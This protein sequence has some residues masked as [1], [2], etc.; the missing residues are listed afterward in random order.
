MADRN[1]LNELMKLLNQP[2]PIN[3]AL[4]DQVAHHLSGS[5]EPIDP[6]LADEYLDLTRLAQMK[7]TEATGLRSYPISE[8]LLVDR[9]GWV[10][11]HLRSFRYVVDPLADKLSA[12]PGAGP[13]GSILKP[14]G[15]ALLGIQ[16]GA[17]VG[18]M[19]ETALGLFDAG[20]PTARP[21]GLTYLLPHIEAFA[22]DYGLDPRQVRLWAAL[23]ETAHGSLAGRSWVRPRAS[24]LFVELIGAM[25]LDTDVMRSFQENLAD[26]ARLESILAEAGG[27]AGLLGGSVEREDLEDIRRLSVM[28]EGY[29]SYLAGRAAGGF[30]PDLDTIRAAM[31]VHGQELGNR[32]GLVGWADARQDSR[33][34][35]FCDEVESRWGQQALGRMW[36]RA[37]NLPTGPELEDTTGWAARVLL[38]DPFAG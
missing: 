14:L 38:Q 9:P 25:E 11:N 3:W 19:S 1:L 28:L 6:W 18:T 8:T 10:R 17:M 22:I 23:R 34:L 5:P 29:G 20:L 16:M 32:P 30:L 31:A 4:A 37:E 15:P 12:A 7:I 33:G 13:L 21:T 27:M 2:G 26:P 24:G 36:D 35:A